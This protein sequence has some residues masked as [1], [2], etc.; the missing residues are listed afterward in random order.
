MRDAITDG[1]RMRKND[2]LEPLQGET[3]HRRNR[4]RWVSD[5]GQR[6]GHA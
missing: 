2:R 3:E 6:A 5:G 4:R 1:W